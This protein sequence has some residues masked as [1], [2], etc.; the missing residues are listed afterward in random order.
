[1][2]PSVDDYFLEIAH[3]VGKRATCARHNVGCVIVRDKHILATG[4]NGAPSGIK[5]CLDV[6]CIREKENIP[7]GVR[8][9][10]CV[11]VHS[12]QNAIVQAAI[13]GTSI[14]GATLYCTHQPCI[15]CAKMLIN[16]GIKRIVYRLSY[17]DANSLEML[18]EAGVEVDWRKPEIKSTRDVELIYCDGF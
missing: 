17:P 3:V 8:H 7:S 4:Y 15:L 16:S 18:K 6:G 11:A 13:H 12:E 10:R 14:M 1:V 9:E 2:R 5:H